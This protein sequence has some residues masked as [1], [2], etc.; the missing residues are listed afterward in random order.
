M[1]R[2]EEAGGDA[3][4]MIVSERVNTSAPLSLARS[5]ERKTGRGR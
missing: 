5:R 3:I 4:F 1:E 2:C